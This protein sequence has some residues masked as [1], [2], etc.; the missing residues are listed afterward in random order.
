MATAF[1]VLFI[2]FLIVDTALK[3]WLD[4][5]EINCIKAHRSAVPE[6]FAQKITLQAHQKAADYS[7]EN[8]KFGQKE[9]W[10]NLLF[11]L[12]ATF[13]GLIQLIYD[14]FTAWFGSGLITQILIVGCFAIISSILDLPFSWIH[15]FKLEEKYG[16][17]TMKPKQ[18]FKDLGVS[19]ALSVILGVPLL[20]V[21]FW[22]W[23]ASGQL[24]WL[25]A[26]LVYVLFNFALL[27]V[28]P[29]LIAPLF[30]KFENLPQGELFDKVSSLLKKTG[31]ESNGL[32]VM[33]ASKRNSK[34][35]AY[36]TGF[37]KNKRIVFFDTLIKKLT[38]DEIE[39]V[40]AHELGHY[41]LKHIYKMMA[42]S[43]G[44]AFVIFALLDV[45]AG[46]SWFYEG[47]GV[48]LNEGQSHAVALLLF[49]L[50]LPVFTFPFTPLS[51][52]SSRKHEF[53]ADK[54]ATENA[55][56]K[57]LITALVK[58]FS[59]N[60]STLTPDPIYSAF[61]SSHP[62]AATRINAIEKLLKNEN[63]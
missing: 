10:F 44:I 45:F 6:A 4:S 53:E 33:D 30:N 58:L 36:M 11:L 56:G 35:N 51:S 47:L 26:W 57:S 5:R 27:W 62:D 50:A 12:I 13:G 31:F 24:W 18:F 54:F 37:G 20:A 15:Q 61:Y 40:L 9:R 21:I 16:F 8:I 49:S 32:Y 14:C 3:F 39:A 17:N 23:E 28:Y 48:V 55:D 25:W 63:K 38:P 34:G 46:S 43:F 7:I 2:I 60:A 29:N 19:T 52:L 22:L 59:D 41:K 1:S 42:V